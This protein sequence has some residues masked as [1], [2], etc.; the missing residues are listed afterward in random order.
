[1]ELVCL[2]NSMFIMGE[3]KREIMKERERERMM[4]KLSKNF[5]IR[6]DDNIVIC[7]YVEVCKIECLV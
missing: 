5:W 7:L 3:R 6:I 2:Y 1:M 4:D